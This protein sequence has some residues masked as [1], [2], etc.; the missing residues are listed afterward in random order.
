MYHLI[1]FLSPSAWSSF[2]LAI[3]SAESTTYYH[4][5]IYNSELSSHYVV[6]IRLF[7]LAPVRNIKDMQFLATS[8]ILQSNHLHQLRISKEHNSQLHPFLKTFQKQKDSR[9]SSIYIGQ[10]E[11]VQEGNC[12]RLP[13]YI[14]LFHLKKNSSN[15]LKIRLTFF[16]F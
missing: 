5:H 8:P 16:G 11:H 10:E 2:S 7:Y 6:G 15:F 4:M 1:K 3:I 14:R 9:N 13:I 12:D